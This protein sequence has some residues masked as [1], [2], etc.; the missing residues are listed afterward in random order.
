MHLNK[1]FMRKKSAV[2]SGGCGFLG[3]NLANRLVNNDYEVTLVITPRKNRQNIASIEKQVEVVEM[4]INQNSYFRDLIKDKDYF[5]HFAWQTDLI[6]SMQNPKRDIMRDLGG[7]VNLL[8]TCR[9]QKSDLKVI[10][11]STVTVVG[12]V[13]K[14]PSN[15]GERANP[16]SIYDT[17]KL[18]SEHYLKVYFETHGINFSCLRLS[19]VFGEMQRTDNPRRGIVNYMIGRALREEEITVYGDGKLIRDY[20][21]VQNFIDAF[22]LAAESKET[23]GET[24]V[25]G[26][27][28]GKTLNEVSSTISDLT[29]ELIGIDVKVTH[30]PFPEGTHPINKRNFIADSRKFKTATGWKPKSGFEEGIR[31]TIDFYKNE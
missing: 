13:Q 6:K 24:Y 2:I 5:F 15:E 26:S 16:L 17:N 14:I 7:L 29:K 25:L 11:P 28:N 30:E 27:G 23:N 18:A 10:F 9:K 19:N 3:S 8:E 1:K 4:E 21:Y 31:K 20:S 22:I 12:N